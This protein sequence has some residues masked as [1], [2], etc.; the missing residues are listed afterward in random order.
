MKKLLPFVLPTA[1][2]LFVIFLGFRW[3][4]QRTQER[5]NVPE[6]SAG[7]EIEE[8]SATE[9]AALEKMSQGLGDFK[10]VKMTGKGL[11]EIRYEIKDSKVF[12]SVNANLETEAGQVYKLWFKENQANDFTASKVLVEKKG[13]LLA[14]TVVSIDKLPI[15]VEVRLGSQVV[16]TGQIQSI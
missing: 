9:L 12:L 15:V 14:T 4:K 16:L 10:V 6:V 8:L 5:L 11:G 7:T 1:A 2:L 13:G 3:Y